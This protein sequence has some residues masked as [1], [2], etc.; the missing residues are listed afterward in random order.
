MENNFETRLGTINEDI[1][2][3]DSDYELEEIEQK[4]DYVKTHISR[5]FERLQKYSENISSLLKKVENNFEEQELIEEQIDKFIHEYSK[6]KHLLKHG[7]EIRIYKESKENE[8]N[9]HKRYARNLLIH[10]GIIPPN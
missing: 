10:Y 4:Y 2:H 8:L 1:L 3:I 9:N 5:E 6:C 7:R